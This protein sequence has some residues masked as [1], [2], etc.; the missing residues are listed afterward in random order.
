[1]E[2]TTIETSPNSLERLATTARVFAGVVY[3]DTDFEDSPSK[4]IEDFWDHTIFQ[5]KTRIY[6]RIIRFFTP[7]T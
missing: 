4:Y 5:W 2:N 7:Q 1:M 6:H 3:G